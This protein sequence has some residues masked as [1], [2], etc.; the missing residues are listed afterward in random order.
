MKSQFKNFI[1]FQLFSLTLAALW[2]SPVKALEP[3]IF[4]PLPTENEVATIARS[5]PLSNEMSAILNRKVMVKYYKNY[6]EVLQAFVKGEVDIAQLGP[7]NYVALN[8]RTTNLQPI[9][10]FRSAPSQ[11]SY[12]CVLVTPMDGVSTLQG[13][14]QVSQPRVLLTQ[15]LSTCGWLSAE[16]FFADAG[17]SL[18]D[19]EYHYEG[20]HD[21]VALAVLRNEGTVGSVADFMAE[22]FEGL[23][24]KVLKEGPLNPTFTLVANPKNLLPQEVQQLQTQLLD[25]HGE[26]LHSLAA[27]KFGFVPF[28]QSM[29]NQFTR[30]VD[31]SASINLFNNPVMLE[32]QP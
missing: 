27:A 32:S 24:L 4:A 30:R 20:T 16:A 10:S 6:N 9:V 12:R 1:K 2:G 28:D 23:G 22:R 19:Y 17:L 14:T 18:T 25:F 8:K 11:E 13:I 29:M 31:K 26:T 21:R 15:P 3:L 5:V 7:L